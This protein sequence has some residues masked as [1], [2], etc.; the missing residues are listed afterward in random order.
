[1]GAT[2]I[3]ARLRYRA[4][5]GKRKGQSRLC[6]LLTFVRLRAF[7]QLHIRDSKRDGDDGCEH[8]DEHDIDA[9]QKKQRDKDDYDYYGF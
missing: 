1:V 5:N 3:S 6:R 9:Q 7:R 4:R 2:A 8:E